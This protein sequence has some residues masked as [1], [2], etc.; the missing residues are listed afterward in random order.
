MSFSKMA[1]KLY[2]YSSFSIAVREIYAFIDRKVICFMVLTQNSQENSRN[3]DA[4]RRWL[5]K[6]TSLITEQKHFQIY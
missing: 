6:L 5:Y 1:R 3:Q 2:C 4:F